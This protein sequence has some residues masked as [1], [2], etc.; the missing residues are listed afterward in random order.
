MKGF[1]RILLLA[2]AVS[3]AVGCELFNTLIEPSHISLVN[4]SDSELVFS[5]YE[6]SYTV[7]F[8]T[9]SSWF[10]VSDSYWCEIEP[11]EGDKS[12][13]ELIVKVS[14]NTG[15]E[16][17]VAVVTLSTEDK[18][19]SVVIQVSQD[20]MKVLSVDVGYYEI[21]QEGGRMAV[22]LQYNVN[23]DISISEDASW[24]S[25]VT[26]KSVSS[27]IHEF[28]VEP[29]LEEK[30]RSALI[31]F[32]DRS[33]DNTEVIEVF[34]YGVPPRQDL[35]MK[36]THV[37]DVF[38]LPEFNDDLS[39]MIYWDYWDYDGASSDFGSMEE[40]DYGSPS[41][42]KTV[43]FELR[44]YQEEFYVKFPDIKGFVEIDLSGL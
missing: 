36:V 12:I 35:V 3:Y 16:D 22:R 33:R 15:T 21:P 24:I 37:N 32:T 39:G 13:S 1:F 38:V 31:K 6:D 10:A 18:N 11:A 25:E 42:E 20:K 7:A 2:A 28:V 17:R 5:E 43:T 30:T 27:A 29:N 41:G 26:T 14:R 9:N 19:E 4:D 23:Y 44:G 40:Y 34:Q 8:T